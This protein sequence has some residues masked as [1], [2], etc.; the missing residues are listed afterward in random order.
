MFE[1]LHGVERYPG[2]GVGLAIVARACDRLG[3]GYGVDSVAG[4]GTRFWVEL[5]ADGN[6]GKN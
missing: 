5:P 2:T 4:Q 6:Y 3:G 1:R